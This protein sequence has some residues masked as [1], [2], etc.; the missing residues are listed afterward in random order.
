MEAYIETGQSEEGW[1]ALEEALTIRPQYGERY[2][3]ADLYRLKGELLLA[4]DRRSSASLD[5]RS[6]TAI[7][8]EAEACFQQAIETA[9]ELSAKSFEL[10]AAMSIARLWQQQGKKGEAH[11]MLSKIYNWLTEG[12]DRS[13]ER[14]VGKECRL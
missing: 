5:Q 13:E 9:R 7:V 2:W 4:Q 1:T 10:R 12:F 11:R 8:V 6:N 14:R 3:E